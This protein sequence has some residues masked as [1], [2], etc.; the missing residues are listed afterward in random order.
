MKLRIEK[1]IQ[2]TKPKVGSF[3]KEKTEKSLAR[4]TERERRLN[5]LN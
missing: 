1:Q 2:S 3:E 5:L 4:L